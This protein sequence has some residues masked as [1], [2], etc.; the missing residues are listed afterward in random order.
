MSYKKVV[1]K[2]DKERSIGRFHH[3]IFSGAIDM[4]DEELQRG[5]LVEVY[6][7]N[8]EFL[9]TGYFNDDAS[10][11]VRIL[12]F[13]KEAIDEAFFVQKI[14]AAFLM[15]KKLMSDGRNSA[16]RLIHGE[17]DYLPGLVIDVYH[18]VAVLQAHTQGIY[19]LRN[20][21]ANA[22]KEVF[23]AI[24]TIFFNAEIKGVPIENEFLLGQKES[25]TITENGA[26]FNVN[27]KEGQ[28]T[29][30]FIDQRENRWLLQQMAKGKTVLNTFSYSGGFSV[31]ALLG[32]ALKVTS[33]D[34]SKKAIDLVDVN[35][36]LNKLKNHQSIVGDVFE[37]LKTDQEKYDI[38]VLDPPAF[39]KN[40]GAKH[41]AVQAYKRLNTAGIKK[42]NPGGLLLTFS[43]SQVIDEDLFLNTVY[44]AALDTGKKI[45]IL[46]KLGQPIDHPVNLYH[47]ETKYLKGL[48]LYIE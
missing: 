21:I 8:D 5:E 9:C 16:Y 20:T 29:G 4:I 41:Q 12:S 31:H 6:S 33:I 14:N 45:R 1:L 38:V 3:W 24:D 2:K 42:L 47:Q 26:L 18:D 27:W 19:L 40:M 15:R 30:F 11:A 43:C 13:K 44:S 28:K 39:A 10:I 36:K 46:K 22:I 35:I 23:P 7:G 17:G 48:L 25:E 34:V 37:F 32:G